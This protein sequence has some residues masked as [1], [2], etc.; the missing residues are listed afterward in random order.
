[1]DWALA[2]LRRRATYLRQSRIKGIAGRR[3][4]MADVLAFGIPIIALIVAA[5]GMTAVRHS[6]GVLRERLA[7]ERDAHA[8]GNLN[9]QAIATKPYGDVYV[10]MLMRDPADA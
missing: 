10:H 3:D 8:G 6:T 9:V 5:I 2:C 1:M 4:L 7:N